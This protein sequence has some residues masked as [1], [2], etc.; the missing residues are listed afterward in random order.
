MRF[1]GGVIQ[2]TEDRS[3]TGFRFG[4]FGTTAE[5]LGESIGGVWNRTGDQD[6]SGL[7]GH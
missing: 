3:A 2:G 1:G 6:L 7:G 4:H 5:R